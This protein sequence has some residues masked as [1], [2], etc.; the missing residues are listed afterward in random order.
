M[1]KKWNTGW[2]VVGIPPKLF[3][4]THRYIQLA[5]RRLAKVLF[6]LF[7]PSN[8]ITLSFL[9]LLLLQATGWLLFGFRSALL[10]IY[11]FFVINNSSKESQEVQQLSSA[12]E[13]LSDFL[14][15]TD[16]VGFF[17]LYLLARSDRLRQA[18]E[19]F[20]GIR[21]VF[22]VQCSYL[23]QHFLAFS[24][25]ELAANFNLLKSPPQA[26]INHQP[27]SGPATDF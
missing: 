21:I 3:W 1:Q 4:Y 8:S 17:N 18:L 14:S 27:S 25:S 9:I 7:S 6:Y 22:S 23:Q 2:W 26:T 12:S 11:A 15:R 19:R 13:A 10:V 24:S 20:L 5:K 16:R